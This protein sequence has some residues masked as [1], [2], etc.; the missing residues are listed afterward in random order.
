MTTAP[1][2]ASAPVA[3]S[4]AQIS[5]LARVFGVLF[6]P[7]ATFTDIA[8]TPNWVLPVVIS[9]LLSLASVIVMNQRVDWRDYISQQMDK[10]SQA[11]Q[12]SPEQR[13]KQL[14]VSIAIT[15]YVVYGIGLLGAILF[16]VIV[17]GIMMLAYNVLAG[18]GAAYLQSISIAAHSLMV[19][20][21]SVPI[22][23]LVMLLRPKGTV[24]P[25]NPV[26]TNL[27][28]FLPEDVP[29]WLAVFGKSIDIFTIWTLVLIAVGFAAVNSKKLKGSKSYLI[30]FSVWGVMVFV[31]VLWSLVFS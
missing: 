12:L 19:G 17:G 14:D 1:M 13:E 9:T 11:P 22:F 7:K 3:P 29:K 5:P 31:K 20:I 2:P 26:A 25:N 18:A 21:F 27:A 10:N 8:R 4:Q 28:A 16:A 23:I 30:V 15:K 6:S 24:D